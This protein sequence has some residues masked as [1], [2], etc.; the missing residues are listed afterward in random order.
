[1]DRLLS[2]QEITNAIGYI[3]IYDSFKQALEN[4]AK[5]QLAKADKWW[6][7]KVKKIITVTHVTQRVHLWEKL[8]QEIGL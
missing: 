5:A 3:A 2:E 8:K 6:I 7:E 4:V 1:M